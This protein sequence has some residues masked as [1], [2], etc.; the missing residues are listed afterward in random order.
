VSG[1]HWNF[2]VSAKIGELA[3]IAVSGDYSW[4]IEEGQGQ[5]YLDGNRLN[6]LDKRGSERV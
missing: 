6:K 5:Y 2:E 1:I 3:A 4:S